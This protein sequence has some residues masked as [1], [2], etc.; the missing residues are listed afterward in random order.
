LLLDDFFELISSL[1]LLFFE[2][3]STPLLLSVELRSH[4]LLCFLELHPYALL[5]F[6]YILKHP[7]ELLRENTRG[8][9]HGGDE[10]TG[11]CMRIQ[12][13]DKGG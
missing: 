11:V 13:M 8:N 1:L 10:V 2:L 6:K 3:R 9:A 5:W 12:S 4:S 7:A